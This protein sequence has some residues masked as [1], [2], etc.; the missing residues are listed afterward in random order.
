MERKKAIVVGSGIA[1]LATAVRI[2]LK[3]YSV[4]VYESNSFPGGKASEIML[5]NYRFDGGPSLFTMP[6]LVDDLFKAAGKNPSDYYQY[7]QKEVVCQYFWNDGTELTAWADKE[8]FAKEAAEKTSVKQDDILEYLKKAEETYEA[9]HKVFLENSLHKFSL[10]LN[11]DT[12]QGILKMHKLNL[13][14]S[15]NE[16]NEKKLKDPKMVQL[17][18]RFATYNGSSPFLTPGVM[19]IIPHLE[20]NMG[21]FYPKGGIRS[22]PNSVYR[23]AK[24]L[25]VRFHFNTYVDEIVIKNKVVRGV[26]ING[27]EV[28]AD[29]VISNMDVVPTYR[30]LLP[31][32]KAPEK[33]LK[34]PRSSSAL[35]FYWGVRK[36]FPKLNLHNI[37]FSHDYKTEFDHIFNKGSVYS[38]P[39]VYVNI[40]SKEE[41]EDA[42]N[43]ENWFVMVNVP[44]NTGQNWEE[45]TSVV[46][47]NA[48]KKLN[49]ILDVNM[50]D[51]IEEE[52]TLDPVKIEQRTSS[53]QGALYGASSNNMMAAFLRH[54][55][56]SRKIKGLYF[57]GGS[58][59][60]GGG[61]PLCLLSAK[62]TADLVPEVKEPAL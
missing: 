44:P 16:I 56:F 59:H 62:I 30:K 58:V 14:S 12:F 47:E 49:K 51:L 35:I 26:S 5:G 11:K 27:E 34:Q 10:M 23:L 55:N 36:A 52:D 3:G 18:N 8:K 6:Q 38:D 25:G 7:K 13:L 46:R 9:T 1:G 33:I 2:A 22:I 54:A 45:L 48:I 19:S 15:L 21:S 53:Y 61:I 39:T 17:F 20:H 60:P 57:C 41:P 32:E 50:Y 31:N 29:L 28:P 37:F 40:S 4:E 43:G 24:D 42:P